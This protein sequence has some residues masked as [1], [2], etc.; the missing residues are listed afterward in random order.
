MEYTSYPLGRKN[1]WLVKRNV[2]AL[3]ISI[4]VIKMVFSQTQR[5]NNKYSALEAVVAVSHI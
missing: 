3:R 5:E 2:R 1:V 4:L